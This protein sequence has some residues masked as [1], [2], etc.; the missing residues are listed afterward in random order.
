VPPISPRIT[1]KVTKTVT[2]TKTATRQTAM[3]KQLIKKTDTLSFSATQPNTLKTNKLQKQTDKKSNKQSSM[4]AKLTD[5]DKKNL[6]LFDAKGDISKDW[7]IEYYEIRGVTKIRKQLK[8][9]LNRFKT[10]EE[11]YTAAKLIIDNL[12]KETKTDARKSQD[13]LTHFIDARL[14]E[15]CDGL[16]FKTDSTYHSKATMFKK[17][18]HTEGV[19]YLHQITPEVAAQFLKGVG[20]TRHPTTHNAYRAFLQ[21]LFDSISPN[22][23]SKIKELPANKTPALCFQKKQVE[24]LKAYISE[25]DPPLWLFI[26]FMYYCLIR[27]NELRQLKIQDVFFEEGKI[28]IDGTISKNKKTQYVAIPNVFLARLKALKMDELKPNDYIFIKEG[29]AN[30]PTGR[31][32]FSKAHQKILKHLGFDTT[33]NKLYSWKHQGAKDFIKA[34]GHIKQL[35]LQGRWH[36]LDQ[37]NEYLR[38]LGVDD[39]NEIRLLYP[40]L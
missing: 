7:F 31:D 10:A 34:G 11:R 32:F 17:W 24:V 19:K 36:S 6:R 2:I 13:D 12:Q 29:T 14:L 30:K 23:F 39:L 1:K 18:C 22:P 28:R 21:N 4:S 9:G 20:A 25:H 16:R 38:S 15:R 8:G 33:K 35:Q 26:E 27:P 37:M 40:E 5:M 3:T